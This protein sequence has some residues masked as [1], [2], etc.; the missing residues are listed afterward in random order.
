[1]SAIFVFTTETTQPPPRVFSVND[2]L[3]CKE[4]V[5]LTSLIAKFFHFF[6]SKTFFVIGS[7]L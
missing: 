7:W 6:F 5:L 4:A 3:T 1:M 2:A